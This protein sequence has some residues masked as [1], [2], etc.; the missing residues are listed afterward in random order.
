MVYV[1]E[2]ILPCYNP[3]E[4]IGKILF[5][6]FVASKKHLQKSLVQK[7]IPIEKYVYFSG[8]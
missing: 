4:I 2:N 5:G 8:G 7:R 6:V 3:I 1:F